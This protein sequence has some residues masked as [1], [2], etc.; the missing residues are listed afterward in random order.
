MKDDF[1]A[2]MRRAALLTRGGDVAGATR[3]IRNA[4]SGGMD[5]R[6]PDTARAD[7]ASRP[8]QRPDLRL[9]KPGT[10]TPSEPGS[11][12]EV[13]GETSGRQRL[14]RMRKPLGEVLRRLREGNLR[15]GLA[16]FVAG[17]EHARDVTC[18]PATAD[19]RRRAV[20]VTL[21]HL[22]RRRTGLQTLYPCLRHRPSRA[23]SSSCCTAASRTP[24]T[25]RSAQT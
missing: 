13:R 25:S 5:S 3:A 12:N 11:S 21:L 17:H 4:L 24:T 2:A 1:A 8:P 18:D 23:A 15:T 7:A 19:T 6:A 16:R 9:V 20:R 10:E 22:R 14:P